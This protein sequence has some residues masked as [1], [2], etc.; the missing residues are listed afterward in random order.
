[1]TGVEFLVAATIMSAATTAVVGVQSYMQGRFQAKMAIAPAELKAKVAR[2]N[3]DIA[4]KLGERDAK[5]ALSA[6]KAR[7][8][9]VRRDRMRRIS[10]ARA[11]FGAMG[12]QIAGTPLEVLSD[13]FVTAELDAHLIRHQGAVE[14]ANARLQAQLTARNEELNAVGAIFSGKGSAILANLQATSSLIAGFGGAG[15]TLLGGFD[16]VRFRQS[17]FDPSDN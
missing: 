11:S 9:A 7:E 6:A 12:T 16:E 1:M 5:A 4:L 15:A 3:A 8:G 14:A 13:A 10:A 2:Q 17:L